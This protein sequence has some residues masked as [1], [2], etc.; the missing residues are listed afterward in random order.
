MRKKFKLPPNFSF[1]EI[2]NGYQLTIDAKN[3]IWVAFSILLIIAGGLMG[4]FLAFFL[5]IISTIGLIKLYNE[6]TNKYQIHLYTDSLK[7]EDF[8]LKYDQIKTISFKTQGFEGG[9]KVARGTYEKTWINIVDTN[10]KE[11]KVGQ[12]F[13]INNQKDLIYILNQFRKHN[14]E[15]IDALV[16][17][18][19]QSLGSAE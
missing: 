13:T 5:L 17:Q 7:I 10:D 8:D 11:I 3:P 4:Y 18:S 19:T 14:N 15:F 6:S 9:G 12:N 1:N 16:T 2:D